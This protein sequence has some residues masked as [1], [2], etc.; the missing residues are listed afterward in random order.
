MQ[1]ELARHFLKN[2]NAQVLFFF[3]SKAPD[4]SNEEACF[5]IIQDNSD[6][7]L[8]FKSD[9]KFFCNPTFGVKS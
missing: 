5:K 7:H 4:D 1:L 8:D 6:M 2:K 9:Y 3:I